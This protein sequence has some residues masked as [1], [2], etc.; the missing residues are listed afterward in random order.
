MGGLGFREIWKEEELGSQDPL[1]KRG[2]TQH[3][4]GVTWPLGG[5]SYTLE[6]RQR[7]M[8]TCSP[9]LEST[10]QFSPP[11]Q[12]PTPPSILKGLI[13]SLKMPV[14]PQ[15]Q[16]EHRALKQ[17]CVIDDLG[18]ANSPRNYESKLTDDP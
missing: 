5:F 9:V 12:I 18:L 16:N 3:L 13:M 6:D 1:P 14:K 17:Y 8:F 7:Q 4:V 10:F 15:C 11:N 2:G